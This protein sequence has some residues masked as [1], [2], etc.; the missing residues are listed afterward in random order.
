MQTVRAYDFWIERQ[1]P[2]VLHQRAPIHVYTCG[3]I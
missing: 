1:F 3:W 2:R